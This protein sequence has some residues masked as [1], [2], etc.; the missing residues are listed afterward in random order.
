MPS[1]A[2]NVNNNRK[3]M[4][5]GSTLATSSDM[6]HPTI[7]VILNCMQTRESHEAVSSSKSDI[8]KWKTAHNSLFSTTG[9]LCNFK[10]STD[11]RQCFNHAKDNSI[12]LLDCSHRQFNDAIVNNTPPLDFQCFGFELDNQWLEFEMCN[13]QK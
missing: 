10:P 13:R 3:P 4:F 7:N 8:E 1:N 2:N 9:P 12:E 6:N 11:S 5:E